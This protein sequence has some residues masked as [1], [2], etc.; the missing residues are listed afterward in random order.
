M[1]SPVPRLSSGENVPAAGTT[2]HPPLQQLEPQVAKH[3]AG[4]LMAS[5]SAVPL[6]PLRVWSPLSPPFAPPC[7]GTFCQSALLGA[8]H[9]TRT[10][11][12]RVE[13]GLFTGQ[14]GSENPTLA[15]ARPRATH[16]SQ[17][18]RAVTE[19]HGGDSPAALDTRP[20]SLSPE[21]HSHTGPTGAAPAP[22]SHSHPWA[23]Q[24]ARESTSRSASRVWA[25]WGGEAQDAG[26]GQAKHVQLRGWEPGWG[27]MAQPL[28]GLGTRPRPSRVPQ[29]EDRSSERWV[30]LETRWLWEHLIRADWNW[31]ARGGRGEAQH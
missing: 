17:P 7:K 22:P 30:S 3:T 24:A 13:A 8:S 4:P 28:S 1:L 5:S 29:P 11:L 10:G 23:L 15:G 14:H 31:G 21:C 26:P 25:P 27:C 9:G 18:P 2:S 20:S 19:G 6:W 16:R 12:S